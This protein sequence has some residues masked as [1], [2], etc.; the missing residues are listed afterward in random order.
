MMT[1]AQ[2]QGG[3]QANIHAK[4]Y[5][6]DMEVNARADKQANA[7]ASTADGQQAN[8]LATTHMDAHAYAHSGTHNDNDEQAIVEVHNVSFCYPGAEVNTLQDVSLRITRG[9]FVAVI[10]SNGSGKSTLCKCLNGLIPTYYS[11]D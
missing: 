5:A 6:T 9:D 2:A 4:T 3:A 8:V 7:I 1:M 11:G 10:G